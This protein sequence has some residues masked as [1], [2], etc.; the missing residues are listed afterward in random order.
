MTLTGRLRGN[1][2]EEDRIQHWR[3]DQYNKDTVHLKYNPADNNNTDIEGCVVQH[4]QDDRHNHV[5]LLLKKIEPSH[6]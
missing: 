6:Q 3:H 4:K 1:K 2:S 5:V